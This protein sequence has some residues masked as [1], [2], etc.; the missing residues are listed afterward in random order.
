[1][2][3]TPVSGHECQERTE[4]EQSYLEKNKLTPE[5]KEVDNKS[6]EQSWPL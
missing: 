1:M 6:G 2:Y 3:C 5:W 4:Q